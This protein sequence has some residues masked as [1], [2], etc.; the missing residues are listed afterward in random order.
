MLPGGRPLAATFRAF[1]RATERAYRWVA[2]HRDLFTRVL[3]IDS[4]CEV[5]ELRLAK[6]ARVVGADA[7]DAALDQLAHPG[8]VVDGPGDQLDLG[9][10]ADPRQARR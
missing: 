5:S 6:S 8:R 3:R 10:L 7:V 1:P 9:E 4:T 2:A